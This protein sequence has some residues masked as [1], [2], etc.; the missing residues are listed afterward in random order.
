VATIPARMII[1]KKI[2]NKYFS[3]LKIMGFPS[4]D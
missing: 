2:K 3:I 1:P 4:F